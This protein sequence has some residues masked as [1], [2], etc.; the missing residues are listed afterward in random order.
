MHV[1]P[2]QQPVTSPGGER[3]HSADDADDAALEYLATPDLV[4]AW[5]A[6]ISGKRCGS[7]A[8]LGGTVAQS[9]TARIA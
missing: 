3:P 2:T 4:R 9:R 1:L 7:V 8:A 6:E 5:L